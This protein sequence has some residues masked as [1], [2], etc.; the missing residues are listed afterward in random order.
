MW[1]VMTRK[2]GFD[3]VILC[4]GGMAGPQYGTTG[5]GYRLAASFLIRSALRCR[6]TALECKG[7]FL[8]RAAGVRCRAA[9]TLYTG[10]DKNRSVK[11]VK[12]GRSK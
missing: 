7:Q 9:V 5:D 4:T 10:N 2:P 11:A 1:T 8:K 12:R 3:T 6:L